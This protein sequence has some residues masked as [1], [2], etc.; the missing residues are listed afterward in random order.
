MCAHA[1]AHMYA[2]EPHIPALLS[3]GWT[4]HHPHSGDTSYNFL[5]FVSLP[6]LCPLPGCLSCSSPSSDILV[7][8]VKKKQQAPSGVTYAKLHQDLITNLIAVSASPRS[9]NLSQ[10]VWEFLINTSE[11]I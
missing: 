10:L 5:A 3:P 7:A 1:C 11:V 6:M 9:K 2:H 4:T 8:N